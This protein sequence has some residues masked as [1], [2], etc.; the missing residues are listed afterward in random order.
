MKVGLVSQSMDDEERSL[1]LVAFE[2][3]I[4]YKTNIEKRAMIRKRWRSAA[5]EKLLSTS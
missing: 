1:Q 4:L 5:Q 3:A 2:A